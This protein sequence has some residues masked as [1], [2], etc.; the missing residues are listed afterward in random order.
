MLF[1][2]NIFFSAHVGGSIKVEELQ[3]R[4]WQCCM[5]PGINTR[6]LKLLNVYEDPLNVCSHAGPLNLEALC[7]I[8]H[9]P[10]NGPIIYLIII[11]FLLILSTYKWLKLTALLSDSFSSTSIY[12]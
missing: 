7:R 8:C 1:D 3:G 6:L 10:S 11:I 2:Q 9:D 12:V 5:Y 4:F